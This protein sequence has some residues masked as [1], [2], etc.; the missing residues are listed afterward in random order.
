MQNS[1]TANRYGPLQH[2]QLISNNTLFINKKTIEEFTLTIPYVMKKYKEPSEM[3]NFKK[4][5][6]AFCMQTL[7]LDAALLWK[8]ITKHWEATP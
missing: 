6:I 7:C 8:G 3:Q 1:I 5:P 4:N 2:L